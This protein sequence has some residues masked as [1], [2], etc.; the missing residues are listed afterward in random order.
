MRCSKLRV[1]RLGYSI[2]SGPL[3]GPLHGPRVR[4]AELL[5]LDHMTRARAAKFLLLSALAMILSGCVTCEL[6]VTNRTGGSMQFY[7]GHT[8][9]A[10]QIAD[11]ATRTIAHAAG[12][13]I[14]IAQEDEVWEYDAVDVPDF[15]ADTS[16]GFKR[17]TL[18]LTVE[19]SG[20]VT[21]PSGRT[22]EP[23]QK[24]KPKR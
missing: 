12:R 5:S 8:K 13:V 4:V 14:I 1:T 15:A 3:H 17:L 2:T 7:T 24:M 23:S 16:K 6:R 9:K 22:I 18:P 11:G 19:S 21:L 20:I 10:V